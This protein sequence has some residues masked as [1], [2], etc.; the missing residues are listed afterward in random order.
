MNKVKMYRTGVGLSQEQM[1]KALGISTN[2]YCKKETGKS[3]F[4]RSE[5]LAFVSAV[6]Q[7]DASATLEKIFFE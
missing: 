6:K 2:T 3:E 4:T 5:M 1:A 7:K